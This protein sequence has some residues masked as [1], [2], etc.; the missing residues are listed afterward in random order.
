MG[1][2]YHPL[3]TLTISLVQKIGQAISQEAL[4]V[5]FPRILTIFNPYFNPDSNP[6]ETGR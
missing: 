4:L 6:D 5:G 3:R 2:I 1:H